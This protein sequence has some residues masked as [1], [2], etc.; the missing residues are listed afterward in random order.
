MKI[1]WKYEITTTQLYITCTFTHLQLL[2]LA[3]PPPSVFFIYTGLFAKHRM[4]RWVG[5]DL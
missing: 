1:N 4:H 3:F 5:F 2:K